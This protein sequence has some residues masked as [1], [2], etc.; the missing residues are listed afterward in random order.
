MFFRGNQDDAPHSYMVSSVNYSNTK[1]IV[2]YIFSILNGCSKMGVLALNHLKKPIINPVVVLREEFDDWA[3]LFNPDT[4]AASGINPVGVAVWKRMD[5]KKSIEEIVAEINDCFE[6]VPCNALEE[7]TL[8]V[9]SL[10]EKGFVGYAITDTRGH[11]HSAQAG[12]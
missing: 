10:A 6:A 8:F 9:T 11:A 1:Q 12:H 4:A 2:L 3:I 5:G 7:V